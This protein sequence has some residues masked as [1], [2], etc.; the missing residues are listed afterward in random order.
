MMLLRSGT[1]LSKDHLGYQYCNKSP[2]LLLLGRVAAGRAVGEDGPA[3]RGRV[4]VG[5]AV[6]RLAPVCASPQAAAG[7]ARR[8]TP[9][10]ESSSSPWSPFTLAPS[11]LQFFQHHILSGVTWGG[12][13]ARPIPPLPLPHPNPDVWQ[14]S[15]PSSSVFTC[16]GEGARRRA[17]ADQRA[18]EPWAL[19]FPP[20]SDQRARAPWA[21]V[22]AD[23]DLVACRPDCK[24][25]RGHCPKTLATSGN[26]RS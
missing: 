4:A 7:R 21:L 23:A 1:R 19:V 3:H 12:E 25:P 9:P 10:R 13:G 16:G 24:S 20:V 15:R 2:S 17:A 11:A 14:L 8:I 5:L 22:F 18:R 6:G 26:S